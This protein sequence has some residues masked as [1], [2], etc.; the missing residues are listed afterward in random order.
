VY[1]V[2]AFRGRR[3]TL[4]KFSVAQ[5][6]KD[7]ALQF[8]TTITEMKKTKPTPTPSILKRASRITR[9]PLQVPSKDE[10]KVKKTQ[11]PHQVTKVSERSKWGTILE[12]LDSFSNDIASYASTTTTTTESV[13]TETSI[14]TST[15]A[16]STTAA[17]ATV[18]PLHSDAVE[19]PPLLPPSHTLKYPQLPNADT[20]E[21]NHIEE[22]RV[23][24][25]P[26]KYQVEEKECNNERGNDGD[27]AEDCYLSDEE[28]IGDYVY[29]SLLDETEFDQGICGYVE[30]FEPPIIHDVSAAHSARRKFSD[31]QIPASI[32]EYENNMSSSK[33]N[34]ADDLICANCGGRAD[35][36]GGGQFCC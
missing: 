22:F 2:T 9:R 17:A 34:E 32:I 27:E 23:V 30:G 13:A 1:T 7:E 3:V 31:E 28:D 25:T 14:Y 5:S 36:C 11:S 6:L 24:E 16:S 18:A 35:G 29:E 10:S 19:R 12:D 4:A 15:S 21:K 20:S 26:K 33:Y 8:S